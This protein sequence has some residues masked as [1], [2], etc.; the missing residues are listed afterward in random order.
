[1]GY[2]ELTRTPQD[3]LALPRDD[4]QGLLKQAVQHGWDA[5]AKR[6][7]NVA[8]SDPPAELSEVQAHGLAES[9]GHGTNDIA[10]GVVEFCSRGA[11]RVAFQ[12]W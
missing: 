2:I 7:A 3:V 6:L 1:M 4:W 8:S 10:R 11:F 5:T 12:T 9:L